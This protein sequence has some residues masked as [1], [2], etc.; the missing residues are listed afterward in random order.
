MLLALPAGSAFG[1]PPLSP[2]GGNATP[3]I[4]EPSLPAAPSFDAAGIR[5]GLPGPVDGKVSGLNAVA[6][7]MLQDIKRTNP[8]GTMT[9]QNTRMLRNAILSDREMDNGELDLLQ[10]L[11]QSQFRGITVTLAGSETAKV[12]TYPTSS[13]AKKVLQDTL[14][15]PVNLDR[16]WTDGSGGWNEITKAYKAGPIEEA[17]VVNYVSAKLGAEWDNSNMGN[18]Y[19]PLRDLIAQLYG[20]SGLPGADTNTGRTILYKACRQLDNKVSDTL[21]DFLYNWTRPGGNL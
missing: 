3:A 14:S 1:Q 6:F 8:N 11:T 18:A 13:A 9:E 7:A 12:I 4:I 21:P 16:A 5:R 15:P 2:A 20:Y 19:K 10:E 17:R